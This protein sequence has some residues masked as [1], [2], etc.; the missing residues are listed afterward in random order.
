G[1]GRPAIPAEAFAQL[2]IDAGQL[3]QSDPAGVAAMPTWTR[4]VTAVPDFP[5]RLRE[6]TRLDAAELIGEGTIATS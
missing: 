1:L 6:A 2:I 4:V 3:Y 5:A